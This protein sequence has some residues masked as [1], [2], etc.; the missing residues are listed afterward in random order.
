MRDCYYTIKD[1]FVN[2]H[3]T[4]GTQSTANG[5]EL[6]QRNFSKKRLVTSIV[7]INELKEIR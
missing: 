7:S 2:L 1:G 3:Q 4:R 6:K 5:D